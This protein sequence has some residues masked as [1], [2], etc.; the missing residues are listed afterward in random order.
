MI[1]V[2]KANFHYF[3]FKAEILRNFGFAL[4]TPVGIYFIKFAEN[5]FSFNID[6][7]IQIITSIIFAVIGYILIDRSLYIM[8]R[9]YES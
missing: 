8:E 4:M 2:M 3:K 7:T 5:N 1:K 9:N 6:L